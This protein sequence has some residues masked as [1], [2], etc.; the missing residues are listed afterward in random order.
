M[1]KKTS[2]SETRTSN[3]PQKN[4]KNDASKE[5]GVIIYKDGMTV[6]DV[7]TAMGKTNAQIVMKLMQLG[8]MA[9]QNQTVDR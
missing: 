7:A 3:I 6:A 4:K 2:K 5:K 9:S 1:A 8:I